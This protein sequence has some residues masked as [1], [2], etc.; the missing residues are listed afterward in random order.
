MLSGLVVEGRHTELLMNKILRLSSGRSAS[1]MSVVAEMRLVD[2][3]LLLGE[4]IVDAAN[5]TVVL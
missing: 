1:I 2:M 4:E 3:L 5:K